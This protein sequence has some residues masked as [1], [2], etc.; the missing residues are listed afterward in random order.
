MSEDPVSQKTSSPLRILVVEDSDFLRQTLSTAMSALHE[1]AAVASA[2]EGW[3]A[4]LEKT[5]DIVFLDIM[6]PD[7]SGHDLAY[8]IKKRTPETFIVMATASHYAD[9]KEEALFNRVDGFLTKPYGK[10]KI[11]EIIARYWKTRAWN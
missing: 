1:V 7:G 11:D 4:Y 10:D 8:Q 5:P 2:K 3:A 9:D 6:L